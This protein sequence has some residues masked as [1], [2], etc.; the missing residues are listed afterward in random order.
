MIYLD[1]NTAIQDLYIPRQSAKSAGGG[2]NDWAT[3]DYVNSALAAETA[4]TESTYAKKSALSAYTPTSGFTTING[5]T[6]TNGGDITIEGT[7]YSGGSNIQIEENVISVTGIPTEFKTINGSAITGNGDLTIEGKVY[8]AG[9]L[10]NIDENDTIS[11]TGV[12]TTQEVEGLIS[13]ATA[14][15]TGWVEDQHYLTEHQSLSAYSTTSEVE[16]MISA[17]TAST[18][19]WVADQHYLTEHQS[20]SAYSTTQEVEGMISASTASTT[21]WVSDQHYL[22]EHQSLSAYTPTSGFSTINGQVITNGSAITIDTSA[23]V[24]LTQAQ[25]DALV[26]GGTVEEGTIYVITDA[27]TID[28]DDLASKRLQEL[29]ELPSEATDG[30][31][32]NYNGE[33]WRY[34]TGTVQTAW[35]DILYDR[36]FAFR[37]DE[38]TEDMDGQTLFKLR[39]NNSSTNYDEV[40]YDHSANTLS[41]KA[42]NQGSSKLTVNFNNP[43]EQSCRTA[44]YSYHY[45][46]FTWVE[47]SVFV[48]MSNAEQMYDAN[49]GFTL[50]G[51]WKKIEKNDEVVIG[52]IQGSGYTRGIP[53]W[54]RSGEIVGKES[55][56]NT[57]S[58]RVNGS[59]FYVLSHSTISHPNIYAPT[60][61]GTTGQMLISQGN[62][63]PVWSNWIK[64]VQITSDA[65]DALVQA[66]TTDPNT[67]YLIVDE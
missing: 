4:R 27:P 18:T 44:D 34:S 47:G 65:Y 15:T 17:A 56:A 43:S 54:N 26:S 53:R 42:S 36:L 50:D 66:G 39:Y 23:T 12:S 51:G 32:V 8:S 63:A 20:L 9:T 19:G 29:D 58:Y 28:I 24:E 38:L 64:S 11:V 31:M 6:I 35:I 7:A 14:S 21:G 3:K 52:D 62:A 10:I 5:Q 61:S 59:Y 49:S 1:N 22:T 67:L 2:V 41:V 46:Y 48:R 57:L 25:Y 30:D 33:I 40:I 16:G 13:A 60:E 55:D 37:Y 45:Y